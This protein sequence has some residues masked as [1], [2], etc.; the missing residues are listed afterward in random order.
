MVI[1]EYV[2]VQCPV[3]GLIWLN[4]NGASVS[5]FDSCKSKTCWEG[6]WKVIRLLRLRSRARFESKA[7]FSEA[8]GRIKK[9]L[10]HFFSSEDKKR[11]ENNSALAV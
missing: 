6:G 7:S 2:L 4:D 9:I 3:H 1:Y 5:G 10:L 8:L 11:K